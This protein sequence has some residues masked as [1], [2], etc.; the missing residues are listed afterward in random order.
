M[1]LAFETASLEEIIEL[2][3][4]LDKKD[5][6]SLAH[7]LKNRLDIDDVVYHSPNMPG[8]SMLNPFLQLTYSDD[9]NKNYRDKGYVHIDPVVKKGMNALLPFDWMSTKS[10]N[11]AVLR[12]LGD[13]E[14]HK[15]G[16]HGLT[17]PIRDEQYKVD[18]LFSVSKLTNEQ[19]WRKLRKDIVKDVVVFAHYIHAKQIEQYRKNSDFDFQLSKRELEVIAWAAEGKSYDDIASILSISVSTVQAHLE[20]VRHKTNALN[21]PHALSILFRVGILH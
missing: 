9:W 20:S 10:D 13:A 14:S 1:M 3:T 11:S 6:K 8:F 21:T 7:Y 16:N 12:F 5:F 15:V 18:A 2:D 17:V 19:H 4:I